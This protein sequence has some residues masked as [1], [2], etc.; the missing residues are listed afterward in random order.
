MHEK[1]ENVTK[2]DKKVTLK[3]PFVLYKSYMHLNLE[4]HQ[5]V[6]GHFNQEVIIAMEN[7]LKV[8]LENLKKKRLDK[9]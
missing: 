8:E 9:K 4:K 5:S 7:H 2:T 6:H 3:I 1:E